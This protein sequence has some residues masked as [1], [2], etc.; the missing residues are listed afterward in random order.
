MG[1]F[2]SPQA[3]A[4]GGARPAR[5]DTR[6]LSPA[7]IGWAGR[8]RR[9]PH[10]LL[11]VAAGLLVLTLWGAQAFA[12][13]DIV[14]GI[15][16]CAP[17]EGLSYAGLVNDLHR[18]QQNPRVTLDCAGRTPSGRTVPVAIVH[19]PQVPLDRLV[20]V[21]IIARQHGSEEAGMTATM[22]LLRYFAASED[23]IARELRRQIA[24]IMV[25]V[26][27]PDGM[28]ASHRANGAG[29]DL[30]RDWHVFAQPE[31]RMLAAMVRKYR[32][33]SLIDMHELPAVSGKPS[34]RENFIETIG[35]DSSLPAG[36]SQDCVATSGRLA[37]WM[38]QCRIPVNVYYDTT[39]SSLNLCH[40]YFGLGCGIPS[41]LFEAKCGAGRGLAA[42]TRF[43]VLGTLIVSNYALHRYYKG[44]T[45]E[46]ELVVAAT[47]E[48]TPPVEPPAQAAEV[49]LTEPTEQQVVRG[50]LPLQAEVSALPEGGYVLFNVDGVMKAAT[51]AAPHQYLLQTDG[52][53]DGKHT[54][55]AQLCDAAGKILSEAC[56]TFVIDNSLAAGE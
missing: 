31:T 37:S 21:F 44:T 26:A 46:P 56:R 19:D 3:G 34:Y 12:A 11:C 48:P 13:T 20:R 25:P 24:L 38:G 29:A 5:Q 9:D 8:P 41:Y 10:R 51:N 55:A 45:P 43:L 23:P 16:G 14:A 52:Y 28:S 40:R 32:P 17:A 4:V 36:L 1:M 53:A 15:C 50:Q 47:P 42:R 27:N 7:G 6:R 22:S 33:H 54:A 30:N 49:R 35:R 18:L 2:D 39:G